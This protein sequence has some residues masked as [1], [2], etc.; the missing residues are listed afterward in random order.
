MAEYNNLANGQHLTWDRGPSLRSLIFASSAVLLLASCG[1][2]GSNT[3][4]TTTTTTPT[5]SC[6]STVS[7]PI[8]AQNIVTVAGA[9]VSGVD[10]TVGNPQTCPAPNAEVLGVADL[11]ATRLSANNTGAQISRGATKIVILFGK[12]LSGSMQVSVSGQPGD[13]TITN[14]TGINATDGTPGVQFNVFVSPTAALGARSVI[15]R[16]ANNDITTF[17]GGLEV[18]P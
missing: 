14:Q 2:G 6:T 16:A 10:I 3:K 8:G 17:T 11:S 12:G 13:F 5:S 9:N 4:P 1:G 18:I 7:A 15:L